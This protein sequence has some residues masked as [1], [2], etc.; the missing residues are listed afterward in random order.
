[1]KAIDLVVTLEDC[2]TWREECRS[3]G[4]RVVLT[5]GCFDLIHVGHL[6]S[7]EYARSLGDRLVVAIN[8]DRSVKQL[9]GAD[10][11]LIGE[12]DRAEMIAGLHCVDKVVI[13]SEKR[14][15]RVI[16]HIH[17]DLYTKGGDYDLE[18][19]DQDERNALQQ[20][21]SEIDFFTLVGGRSTTEILSKITSAKR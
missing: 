7:L 21:G 15:T 5:N 10:R 20:C 2:L 17:P 3:K 6:R 13:F 1:M 11:P 16:N 4:E 9:K 12:M 8:A 19:M 14:L 18:T